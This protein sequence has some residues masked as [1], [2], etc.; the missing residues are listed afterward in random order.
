MV[1]PSSRGA[2]EGTRWPPKPP[3]SAAGG[4]E[5]SPAEQCSGGERHDAPDQCAG[6]TCEIREPPAYHGKSFRLRPA[7]RMDVGTL[8]RWAARGASGGVG[9]TWGR[10]CSGAA[11]RRSHVARGAGAAQRFGAEGSASRQEV[12]ARAR[13][14]GPVL[15]LGAW[16]VAP[17]VGAQPSPRP[18]WPRRRLRRPL[19][20]TWAQAAPWVSG[21]CARSRRA[22]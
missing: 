2:R 12:A 17:G 5:R 6:S 21:H 9:S 20:P 10:N 3:R 1:W 11:S 22:W 15:G 16:C 4:Y 7:R 18:R 8:R 13:P 19:G 14:L